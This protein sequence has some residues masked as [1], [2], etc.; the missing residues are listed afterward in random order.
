MTE[1]FDQ[2][3]KNYNLFSDKAIRITGYDTQNLVDAKLKKLQNLY[4]Y[5]MGK[6]FHFL[7]Y[8]CGIG[9]LYG[10]V[11]TYFPHAIYTGVDSSKNSVHEARSRFSDNSDFQE[12]NSSQ[13]KNNRYDLIFSS[14]V[15]HHIP[16]QEHSSLIK[17]LSD[18]LNSNGKL[19]IWEHNPINPLTQ[20]IVKECVFDKD[21]VLIQSKKFKQYLKAASLVKVRI[22]Y[23][24]FFP[25][26]LSGFNV[27][28]SF[29][30]WLPLGGQ[31]LATG[32]KR[33]EF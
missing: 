1:P 4:P 7:D 21:A 15:F 26:I 18:L 24:T 25:K 12:L 16:H 33:E 19:V 14:G 5:L 9:N 30:G 22:I 28:D 29:L 8:G 23:T 17:H 11:L 27:F 32:E 20:K 10:S 31:Y 2:F 13:W 6:R 3:S